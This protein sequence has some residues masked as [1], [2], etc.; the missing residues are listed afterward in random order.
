[1]YEV[2]QI[3]LPQLQYAYSVRNY[4]H[5]YKLRV[6]LSLLLPPSSTIHLITYRYKH[7]V[8]SLYHTGTSLQA[9]QYRY[10]EYTILGIRTRRA[11]EVSHAV[12]FT[13]R[14]QV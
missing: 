6:F 2:K 8:L 4:L 5:Q 12:L 9:V 7:T 11:M 1:V 10:V 14:T 3:R 13:I